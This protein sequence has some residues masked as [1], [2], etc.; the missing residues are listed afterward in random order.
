MNPRHRARSSIDGWMLLRPLGAGGNSEVWAAERDGVE[1]ALKLPFVR[2][3]EAEAYMRFRDEVKVLLTL[4]TVTGVLPLIDSSVPERP[5]RIHPAWLATPIATPIKEAIG[6]AP[7]IEEVIG[8]VRL[9]AQTLAALAE[10]NIHHRDIKPGNLFLFEDMWTVGDFGL[11]DFPEKEGLTQSGRRMGPTFFMAPEMM[12]SPQVADGERADVYS[13][14]KTLWVLATGQ[15]FPPQGELRRDVRGM[16]LSDSVPHERGPFLDRLLQSATSHDPNGRPT[17]ME[18]AEELRAWEHHPTAAVPADV[19]HL[20][21]QVSTL[22]GPALSEEAARREWVNAGSQ[23]FQRVHDHLNDLAG[24]IRGVGLSGNVTTGLSMGR[25]LKSMLPR[26]EVTGTAECLW[27]NYSYIPVKAPAPFTA[28]LWVVSGCQVFDDGTT[29]L[30]AGYLLGHFDFPQDSMWTQVETFEPG[31]AI[32][33]MKTS[34]MI[35]GLS[36]NLASAVGA[37]MDRV[38]DQT[39]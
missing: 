37:F 35:A 36:D 19:S 28:H 21:D 3:P 27:Q 24:L 16:R 20:Q 13:L 39:I 22:L 11:A 4:G 12:N 25:Y 1:L 38:K 17:L 5:S 15:N 29:D 14:A 7:T 6:D 9:V 18:F 31:S 33:Q 23:S 30:A 2:N 34:E 10:R 8:G 26:L 32:A